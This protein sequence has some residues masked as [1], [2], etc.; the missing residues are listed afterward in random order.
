MRLQSG[1]DIICGIEKDVDEVTMIDP[2]QIIFKRSEAGTV[3]VLLP[4]IPL[5][6]V[7]KNVSKINH[8]DILTYFDPKET[9]IEYYQKMID[10]MNIKKY[11][12]S[13]E[14]LDNLKN[15]FDEYDDEDFSEGQ[16]NISLEEIRETL[17][18]LKKG[19]L[20]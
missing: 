7:E 1:E 18:R 9:V 11:L 17:D 5:E 16:E 6:L 4:W 10:K 13:D 2:F 3:M 8:S 12:D 19:K 20:H 14:N 15:A